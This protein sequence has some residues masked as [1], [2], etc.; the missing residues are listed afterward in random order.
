MICSILLDFFFF[1]F[2]F[3]SRTPS[4][5]D[6]RGAVR[7]LGHIKKGLGDSSYW[8]FAFSLS[9]AR[10]LSLLN[11]VRIRRAS[12]DF[13]CY[14]TCVQAPLSRR[15]ISLR[16]VNQCR[17][18]R[19]L[20]LFV[21]VVRNVREIKIVLLL[22]HPRVG[23]CLKMMSSSSGSSLGLTFFDFVSFKLWFHLKKIITFIFNV[24]RHQRTTPLRW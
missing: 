4:T 3:C 7:L 10:A 22:Y 8:K 24:W 20:K 5:R 21:L 9:F 19:E 15:I 18:K 6:I 2:V 23:D 17:I 16:I 13:C 1:A 11:G 14:I 12:P